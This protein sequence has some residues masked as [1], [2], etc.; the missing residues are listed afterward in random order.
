MT[1]LGEA[2][3]KVLSDRGSI[4]KSRPIEWS[5]GENLAW[6]VKAKAKSYANT[7]EYVE[8]SN[9]SVSTHRL[10]SLRIGSTRM[11]GKTQN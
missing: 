11:K 10:L 6:S 2:Y 5:I 8:K 7:E 9:S 1:A 3:G 4:Q